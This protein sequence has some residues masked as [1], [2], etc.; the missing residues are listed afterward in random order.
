MGSHWAVPVEV[1]PFGWRI[2]EAYLTAL[3]ASVR[4]RQDTGGQPFVTD[5]G[6]WILDCT[7]GPIADPAQLDAQLNS[8]TGIVAHGLFL[9]VASD[10]VIAGPAGVCH[11]HRWTASAL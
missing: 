2:Q 5:Q 4:I 11:L 10:V 1:I 8:R 3:G 7:F 9:G 6:N